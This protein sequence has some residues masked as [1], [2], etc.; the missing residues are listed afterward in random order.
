MERRYLTLFCCLL[1]VN[2]VKA[3]DRNL[4]FYTSFDSSIESADV[5]LGKKEGKIMGE[6]VQTD[7]VKGKAVNVGGKGSISFEAEKNLNFSTGTISFWFSPQDWDASY[8]GTVIFL[9]MVTREGINVAWLSKEADRKT[10]GNTL[11]VAL[12]GPAADGKWGWGAVRGR[13]ASACLLKKKQWYH[14]LVT[15]D[16]N[17][18]YI[19]LN[20]ESQGYGDRK[21]FRQP[22]NF[23][24]GPGY[25]D[26]TQPQT[27]IDEVKIFDKFLKAEEV[28][29]LFTGELPKKEDSDQKF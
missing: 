24:I 22:D 15:W 5:A 25:V 17:Y 4:T 2:L 19:Y 18:M 16:E 28:R 1:L 12:Y 10:W 6:V 8:E 14:F 20:G 9:R 13:C 21:L 23:Q 7:G 11:C 3:D 27:L 26:K 29:K